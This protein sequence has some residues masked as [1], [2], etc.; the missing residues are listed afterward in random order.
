MYPVF[1]LPHFRRVSELWELS[2]RLTSAQS[3]NRLPVMPVSFPSIETECQSLSA[4]NFRMWFHEIEGA[5]IDR[6]P[7]VVVAQTVKR[8]VVTSCGA[9]VF[10]KWT[11]DSASSS[12]FQRK[13]F[14]VISAWNME[15]RSGIPS[16]LIRKASKKRP[17]CRR[18]EL[19]LRV[20]PLP[21]RIHSHPA[22]S[23]LRENRH[24]SALRI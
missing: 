15:C 1:G 10:L 20:R 3:S 4:P 16:D 24:G 14:N 22:G 19:F 2:D 18:Q 23:V 8:R 17:A 12:Y 6:I 7:I 11:P 9:G 21:E 13:G 5:T